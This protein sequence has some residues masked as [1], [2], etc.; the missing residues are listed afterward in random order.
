MKSLDISVIL[1]EY[2]ID[3]ANCDTLFFSWIFFLISFKVKV[4]KWMKFSLKKKGKIG[5]FQIVLLRF[6]FNMIVFSIGCFFKILFEREVS[7]CLLSEEKKEVSYSLRQQKNKNWL[8]QIT[9]QILL[10]FFLLK[11]YYKFELFF[12]F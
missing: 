8:I 5:L 3:E 2:T 6:D 12:F 4:K 9:L 7:A 11:I 1:Y 10:F